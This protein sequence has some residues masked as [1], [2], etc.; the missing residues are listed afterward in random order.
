MAY[1]GFAA[2]AAVLLFLQFDDTWQDPK[3]AEL[4]LYICAGVCCVYLWMCMLYV[5]A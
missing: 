4:S 3:H 1:L 2:Q 5:R